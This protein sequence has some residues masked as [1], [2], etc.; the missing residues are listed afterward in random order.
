MELDPIQLGKQVRDAV[1]IP[2]EMKTH[3]YS[4]FGSKIEIV[5]DELKDKS[6]GT[7]AYAVSHQLQSVHDQGGTLVSEF[8]IEL[9]E[10]VLSVHYYVLFPLTEV[11]A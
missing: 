10:K 11:D 4:K 9:E 2:E 5:S 7:L 6:I 8:Y 1:K 3:I